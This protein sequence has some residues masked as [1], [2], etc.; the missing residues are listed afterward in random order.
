MTPQNSANCSFATDDKLPG[1]LVSEGHIDHSIRKA[2]AHGVPPITAI[3]MGTINTARYYRLKN[4]GAI[5]P[6]FWAD[7]IVVDDLNNFEVSADLEERAARGGERKI[8]TGDISRGAEQPR[9]TM[10]LRYQARRIL[11]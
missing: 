1:D 2:I 10:N 3:Q 7:F 8:F 9:S 11:R 5:A 6:R 4:H